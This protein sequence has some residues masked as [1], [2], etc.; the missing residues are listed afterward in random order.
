[1]IPNIRELQ[2]EYFKKNFSVGYHN[3]QYSWPQLMLFIL[4]CIKGLESIDGG[5]KSPSA[6]TVR[7]RLRLSNELD[8]F[9]HESMEKIARWAVRLF[10]RHEWYIS[11]DETHTPFF[12]DRK[13]LNKE[14]SRRKKGKYVHGYRADVKGATGSFCFVMISLCCSKI[15]IPLSVKMVK[16]R[17]RYDSW[18]KTELTTALRIKP[19][20][21]ILAD[22]GYGKAVWFI[23][24]LEELDAAYVAR[25]PLRKK[26]SKNK[27]RNGN[28]HLQQWYG[29]ESKE[30]KVLIDIFIARDKQNREYVLISNLTHKR[31]S[32]LLKYYL[33][34]WDIENIFKG[35]DRVELI[36]SSRN[37][38]MRLFCVL[39]SFFMFA[40]WQVARI[41]EKMNSYS[42]RNYVKELLGMVCSAI[43]CIITPIGEI[44]QISRE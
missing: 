11:I 23:K 16:V 33:H 30:G 7:D 2:C 35:A 25:M 29:K 20:A 21:V 28:R 5:A 4:N 27:V 38:L 37:P 40:L 17:E 31:S 8:N 3:V 10:S 6:Q 19:S 32:T 18:L 14:L 36:T 43:G 1:M 26:E 39:T 12:G 42:L 13:K 34:R 24:L 41:T 44:L 15:K 9:F 22:R